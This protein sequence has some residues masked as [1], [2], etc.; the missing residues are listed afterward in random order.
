MCLLTGD[1][2]TESLKKDYGSSSL[3]PHQLCGSSRRRACH[4]M[5]QQS[6]LDSDGHPALSWENHSLRVSF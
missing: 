3:H 4:E 5:F 6:L 2:L 1:E